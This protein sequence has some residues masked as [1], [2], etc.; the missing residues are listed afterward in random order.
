MANLKKLQQNKTCPVAAAVSQQLGLLQVSP[1]TTLLLGLSGG[2]DSCVLLHVLAQISKINSFKII[3]LHVNHG[4]SANANAWADFCHLQTVKYGLPFTIKRVQVDTNAGLGV[5]AAARNARYAALQAEQQVYKVDWIFLAHHQD[6]QAETLLLQLAR[7]AGAKGLAGM[8]IA[9]E[10]RHIFRPLLN[11]SRAQLVI[12][13]KQNNVQ[14]V[15]D[16]SNNNTNFDRNFMRHE[17]VP[18][19]KKRYPTIAQTLARSAQHLAESD[20]LLTELAQLDAEKAIENNALKIGILKLLSIARQH[21]LLRFWLQNNGFTMPSSARLVQIC[22]QILNA[23]N[24][25]KLKL[26]DGVSLRCD[27]DAAHIVHEFE[28]QQNLSWGGEVTLPLNGFQMLKFEIKLGQGVAMQ[29]LTLPLHIKT[30]AADLRLKT[31]L[32]RPSQSLKNLFQTANVAPWARKNWPLIFCNESLIIV[33][34]IGFDITLQAQANALGLTVE[35]LP[36]T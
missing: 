19:L 28:N 26:A 8:A 13:A 35:L 9:D 11:I 36:I 21:N 7:G 1:Q 27:T 12:Y 33:P 24:T 2:L 32:N 18:A 30:R 23:K 16:E 4:L 29:A 14:W 22:S 5:E 17:I 3:A 10:K 31:Q 25:T 20:E 34:N 15:D 6:D